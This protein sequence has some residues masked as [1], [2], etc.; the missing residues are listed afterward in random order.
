M[1]I[2]VRYAGRRAVLV[3]TGQL[4][5]ESCAELLEAV[6]WVLNAG[7]RQVLLDMENLTA[8]DAEGIGGLV[9]VRL[10]TDC[11]CVRLRLVRARGRVLRLIRLARIDAVIDTVAYGV[12]E[13]G[14]TLRAR[15]PA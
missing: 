2:S 13:C 15:R 6:R 4:R 12:I 10:E 9:A 14:P 7:A 1:D 8:I 11:R 3:L 5:G